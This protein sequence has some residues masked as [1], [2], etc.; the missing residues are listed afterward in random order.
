MPHPQEAFGVVRRVSAKFDLEP[1]VLQAT[2]AMLWS[3]D[4]EA[5]KA[6]AANRWRTAPVEVRKKALAYDLASR[7]WPPKASE[8]ARQFREEFAA[9]TEGL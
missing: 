8:A 6:E 7:Q 3:S 1:E 2:T 5:N 4:G 9:F